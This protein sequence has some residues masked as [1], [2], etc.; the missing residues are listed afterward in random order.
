MANKITLDT[1][2]LMKE[3]REKIT[4]L[5]VSDYYGAQLVDSLGVTCILVGDSLGKYVQGE[6]DA[7]SVTTWDMYYYCRIVRKAVQNS[8][9]IV[10]LPFAS[11]ELKDPQETVEQ[12]RFLMEKGGA[13]A[14]KLEGAEEYFP[15]VKALIEAKIPVMGHLGLKET[16]ATQM[17][18]SPK[19][20]KERHKDWNWVAKN[21]QKL[22]DMGAFS[23]L[24]D[25]VPAVL[26]AEIAN[27]LKI[28]VIG[29]GAGRGVDGQS[30]VFHEMMGYHEDLRAKYVKRYARL[31]QVMSASVRSFV[32]D[33]HNLR[34][35]SEEHEI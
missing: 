2:L 4:M 17:G 13:E 20:A 16:Y 22:Q 30:M 14:V 10:D 24:L 34:F 8:L 19:T 3:K 7:L 26:G 9:L 28:P 12:A 18:G 31:S 6:E 33:I 11:Y 5:S 25:C 32:D 1:L 23:V 21:A 29:K 27:A 35:P 15:V